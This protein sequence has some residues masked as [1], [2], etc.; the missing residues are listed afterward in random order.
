MMAARASPLNSSGHE[1][2]RLKVESCAKAW[3]AIRLL[4]R[5]FVV[6]SQGFPVMSLAI[7]DNRRYPA[8]YKAPICIC[9]LLFFGFVRICETVYHMTKLKDVGWFNGDDDDDEGEGSYEKEV[10]TDDE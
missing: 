5:R 4:L 10:V 6:V 3:A 7:N 2:W 9:K 8:T 1:W